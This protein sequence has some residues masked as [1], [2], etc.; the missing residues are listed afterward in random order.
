MISSFFLPFQ[1]PQRSAVQGQVR[2]AGTSR[3]SPVFQGGGGGGGR[4]GHHHQGNWQRHRVQGRRR[5]RHWPG[6]MICPPWVGRAN[7]CCDCAPGGSRD[8]LG[9]TNYSRP[10]TRFDISLTVKPCID[11][12]SLPYSLSLKEAVQNCP[13][14]YYFSFKYNVSCCS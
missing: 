3:R 11:K 13:N 9:L 6:L 1:H 8:K 2:A 4:G 12:A 10:N 5:R 7:S 14:S